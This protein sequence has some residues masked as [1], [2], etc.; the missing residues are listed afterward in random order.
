M[1]FLM[2]FTDFEAVF[3]KRSE[4][5]VQKRTKKYG[6]RAKNPLSG[7]V[8]TGPSQ[9]FFG[10]KEKTPFDMLLLNF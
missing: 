9:F 8:L 7:L 6:K 2:I 1:D 5:R 4:L 3:D 10:I